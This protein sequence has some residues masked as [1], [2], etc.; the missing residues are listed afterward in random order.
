MKLLLLRFILLSF[1]ELFRVVSY[2]WVL[3]LINGFKGLLRFLRAAIAYEKLEHVYKKTTTQQCSPIHHPS[4]HRP[5]PLIYSQKYLLSLGLAVT[6]DNPDIVL[7]RNGAVVSEGDLL[8]DT[9]YEIDA[10]IWNNSFDA[11][12]VGLTVDFSFLSFGVGTTLHSIGTKVVNLGVKGG[13]NHPAHARIPWRTPPAGHLLD[14][15][16]LARPAITT[17]LRYLYFFLKYFVWFGHSKYI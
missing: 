11:P 10:T 8:P 2:K 7:P 1:V 3:A 9:D 13:N 12:I 4:F 17:I 5:D 16:Y 6:W 14:E 15:F